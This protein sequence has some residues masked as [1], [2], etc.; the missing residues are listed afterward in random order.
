MAYIKL[1]DLEVYKIAREI[2]KVAWE[3][4]GS[5]SWQEKKILGDQ[6]LES[7]DSI[8]ANIAEGYGRFHYLDKIKFYYNARGSLFEC[9]HWVE[10]MEDREVG[11]PE[12]LAK[13]KKLLSKEE[14]KL[15]NFIG[16]TYKSR[17]K[18]NRNKETSRNK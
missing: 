6:Y 5:L 10:L 8:G 2:S 12:L 15:N 14:V 1:S 13:L 4:Y 11:N 9:Q 3:I 7:A 18:I 16:S 17:N